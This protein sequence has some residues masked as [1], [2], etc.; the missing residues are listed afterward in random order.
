MPFRFCNP[1][2]FPNFLLAIKWLIHF[3][4][5]KTIDGPTSAP[6]DFSLAACPDPSKPSFIHV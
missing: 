3:L 1:V 4:S 2:P 5:A 6:I